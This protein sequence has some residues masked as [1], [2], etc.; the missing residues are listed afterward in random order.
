MTAVKIVN[1]AAEERPGLKQFLLKSQSKDP[2]L[3]G[4]THQILI[5]GGKRKLRS[6]RQICY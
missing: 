5:Q 3:R 4:L 1:L 6:P 2:S